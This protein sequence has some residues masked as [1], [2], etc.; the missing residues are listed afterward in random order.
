VDVL[1]T[2]NIFNTMYFPKERI[3]EG[4][5]A[6][7]L[8]LKVGGLWI[9]GRTIDA[10][11]HVTFFRRGSEKWEVVAQLGVGAGEIF[12]QMEA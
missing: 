11:N 1:R 5:K 4:A 2:L 9:V 3:L 7:F 6:A 8:S 12:R 10:T